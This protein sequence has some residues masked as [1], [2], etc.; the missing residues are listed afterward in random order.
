MVVFIGRPSFMIK[1]KVK[2]I[3]F[4]HILLY[5]PKYHSQISWT[6]LSNS[7]MR[8]RPFLVSLVLLSFLSSLA[9]TLSPCLLPC[10]LQPLNGLGWQ[11]ERDSSWLANKATRFIL[12]LP[13]SFRRLFSEFLPLNCFDIVSQWLS[14][15]L[16]AKHC[17]CLFFNVTSIWQWYSRLAKLL[18]IQ[19]SSRSYCLQCD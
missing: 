18:E 5:S 8:Q 19:R 13:L 12:N 11:S 1:N 17:S 10:S 7:R 3:L 2:Y 4:K 14:V 9:L 16:K 15:I 6:L